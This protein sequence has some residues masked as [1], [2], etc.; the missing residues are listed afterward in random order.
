MLIFSLIQANEANTM[1]QEKRS[2]NYSDFKMKG[3]QEGEY[4]YIRQVQPPSPF[5]TYQDQSKIK[6]LVYSIIYKLWKQVI[7]VPD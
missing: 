1:K 4:S 3:V 2:L 6:V 5:Y 7:Q